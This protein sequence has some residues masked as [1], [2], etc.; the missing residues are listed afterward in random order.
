MSDKNDVVADESTVDPKDT[1]SDSG[2][3]TDDLDTLLNE[4][5]NDFEK[6]TQAAPEKGTD[7]DLS[8]KVDYLL[9]QQETTASG[10]AVS[11]VQGGLKEVDISAPDEAIEGMLNQMAIKDERFMKAFQERDQNPGHWNKVIAAAS[12]SI[13]KKFGDMVDKPLTDDRDSVANAIR[14]SSTTSDEDAPKNYNSMTDSD[15]EAE[16]LKY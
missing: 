9:K 5:D 6:G 12:K 15:F 3:Q 7:P 4:I 13:A 11:S 10:E 2:A 8:E 16:K 1:T 14:G